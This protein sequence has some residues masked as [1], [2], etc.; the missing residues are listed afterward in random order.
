ML[1]S[2]TANH[3]VAR[4][5]DNVLA[6][7]KLICGVSQEIPGFAVSDG[8]NNWSGFDVDICRAIAIAIF[9]DQTKISITPLGVKERFTA[10]QAGEIDVLVRNDTWTL[11]RNAGIGMDFTGIIFHDW[12]GFMVNKNS[13]INNLKDITTGNICVE[14]ESNAHD[15]ASIYFASSPKITL[16]PFDNS[17]E[18]INAYDTQKC[19]A[20][21]AN[22]SLLASYRSKLSDFNNHIILP[23]ILSKEPFSPS[24]RQGD[25]QWANI[26]RWTIFGLI[27]AEELGI[28]KANVQNFTNSKDPNIRLFLGY[29][30]NLY[31]SLELKNASMRNVISQ[32]GNYGE[33]FENNFGKNSKLKLPRSQNKLWKDGGLI[34]SPIFK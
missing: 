15:N 21:A 13:N 20:I 8:S 7:E 17:T 11:T 12:Q 10:L 29:D 31:E 4:T 28:T 14:S 33:I 6:R 16:L 32:L 23:Q 24:V 1:F 9:N 2:F 22:C 27:N 26:V 19:I 30:S 25:Q 3:T 18:M 5:L 34:Y